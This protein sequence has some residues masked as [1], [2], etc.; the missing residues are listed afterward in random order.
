MGKRVLHVIDSYRRRAGSAACLLHDLLG[1]MSAHS[2]DWHVVTWQSDDGDGPTA[3]NQVT[4]VGA[5][6]SANGAGPNPSEVLRDAARSADVVHLHGL[7]SRLVRA[8]ARAARRAGVP[9]VLSPHAT[10]VPDPYEKRPLGERITNRF[11]DERLIRRAACLHACPQTEA[12]LIRRNGWSPRIEIIPPGISPRRYGRKDAAKELLQDMPQLADQKCLLFLGRIHPIEG[13]GPLLRACETLVDK[14]D[15]WHLVLAGPTPGAWREQ[16]EAAVRRRGEQDRV[17][18]IADPPYE[19]QLQLLARANLLVQPCLS[20]QVPAAALQGMSSTVPVIVSPHCQLPQVQ[21]R[22]AG[23]VSKPN[24][25][26]LVPALEQVL[27]ASPQQWADMGAN[28]RVL[29]AEEFN[30]QALAP[31]FAELYDSLE[32]AGS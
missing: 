19:K 29:V 9:Y 8:A 21:D 4:V 17:S 16:I 31:R 27:T 7:R 12:D 10:L 18:V 1:E 26:A 24:K 30:C 22:R 13:L 15:G 20:L 32:G 14:L 2:I 5:D 25:R 3:E 11:R 23:L 28:G 6:S